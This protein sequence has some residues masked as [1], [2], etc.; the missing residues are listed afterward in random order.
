MKAHMAESAYAQDLGS[1]VFG[2]VGSTPTVR[3]KN[4]KG[5]IDVCQQ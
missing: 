2:H 4:F 1:C 5:R 3:I